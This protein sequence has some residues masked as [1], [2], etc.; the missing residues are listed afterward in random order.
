[1]SFEDVERSSLSRRVPYQR[2][3]LHTVPKSQSVYTVGREQFMQASM[4]VYIILRDQW[5]Q[6]LAQDVCVCVVYLHMYNNY[7]FILKC[8]SVCVV[9]NVMLAVLTSSTH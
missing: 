8:H 3:P 5:L 6:R 9:L 4:Y 7:G 2:L 1:M